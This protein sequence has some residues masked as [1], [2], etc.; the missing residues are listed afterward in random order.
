[1]EVD[2]FPVPPP[3]RLSAKL[4]AVFKGSSQFFAIFVSPAS[5]G[6]TLSLLSPDPEK[7]VNWSTTVIGEFDVDFEAAQAGIAS[8]RGVTL[9]PPKP[10]GMIL[11]TY[12]SVLGLR[13][14]TTET[15]SHQDNHI[16]IAGPHL[17]HQFREGRNDFADSFVAKDVVGSKM[18]KDNLWFG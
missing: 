5:L 1:M 16:W 4:I 14:V 2:G 9:N 11:A 6:W 3:A 17:V 15:A 18:E 12:F 8:L 10:I 13:L 7:P